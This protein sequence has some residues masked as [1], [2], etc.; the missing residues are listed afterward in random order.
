MTVDKRQGSD[1][2]LDPEMVAEFQAYGGIWKFLAASLHA[3]EQG[4]DALT[5]LRMPNGKLLRNCTLEYHQRVSV[6][7]AAVG[8]MGALDQFLD[9][10]A[11]LRE[12]GAANAPRAELKTGGDSPGPSFTVRSVYR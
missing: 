4:S 12:L 2:Q 7:L 3:R 11:T 10:N 8:R 9:E 5:K 6:F 1:P